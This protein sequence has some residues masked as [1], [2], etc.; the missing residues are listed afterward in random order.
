MDGLQSYFN[1]DEDDAGQYE[2]DDNIYYLKYHMN[3]DND[4][5][6]EIVAN[7]DFNDQDFI[8]LELFVIC[9]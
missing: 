9:I 6:D 1:D 4:T 2:D 5:L 7:N 8:F 3:I